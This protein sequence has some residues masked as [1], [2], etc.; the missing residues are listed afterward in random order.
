LLRLYPVDESIAFAP[1]PEPHELP[2]IASMFDVV[3]AVVES[4]ELAYDPS[5][6]PPGKRFIHEPVPDYH[7]PRLGQLLRVAR[8]AAEAAEQGRRVLIHCLGG[9][10]RSATMAAGYLVYRYGVPARAAVDYVRRVRPGAI[11]HPGQEGVVRS[12]EAVLAASATQG[13]EEKLRLTGMLAEAL[14]YSRIAGLHAAVALLTRRRKGR[15]AETL[16]K[17]AEEA[18][19][20]ALLDV[21]DDGSGSRLLRMVLVEYSALAEALHGELAEAIAEEFPVTGRGLVAADVEYW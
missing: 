18:R 7:W 20:I 16:E 8:L 5:R 13:E 2:K 1:M 19:K 3:V 21:E 4:H 14:S 6:L 10:G 11:E 9:S 17:L 15:L 12:L